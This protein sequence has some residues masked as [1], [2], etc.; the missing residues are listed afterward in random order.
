M[1]PAAGTILLDVAF[2]NHAVEAFK[3]Y[4]DAMLDLLLVGQS[5]GIK[6][7]LVD[8]HQVCYV[9]ARAGLGWTRALHMAC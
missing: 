6:D 5:P 8:R 9:I 3:K 1:P 2:Q 4:V 7:T